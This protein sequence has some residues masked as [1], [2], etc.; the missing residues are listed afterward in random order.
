MTTARENWRF[1]RSGAKGL[2]LSPLIKVDC[3]YC[4]AK[5]GERCKPTYGKGGY[6]R[7]HSQRYARVFGA[8]KETP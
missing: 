6:G 7:F 2:L 5:A 8:M 1:K 4:Q 3:P